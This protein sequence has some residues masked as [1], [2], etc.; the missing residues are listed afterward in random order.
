MTIEENTQVNKPLAKTAEVKLS[1][2]AKSLPPVS[3]GI[4]MPKVQPPKNLQPA[5]DQAA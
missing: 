5:K 4:P 3:S 1:E 2:L